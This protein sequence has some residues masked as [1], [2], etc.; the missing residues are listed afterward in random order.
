MWKYR[1]FQLLF[2]ILVGG[3]VAW[4]DHPSE[5]RL[6]LKELISLAET[7]NLEIKEANTKL[8]SLELSVWSRYGAFSPQLFV[9][10]GPVSTKFD[11]ETN[12]GSALFGRLRWNLYRGGYDLALLQQTKIQRNLEVQRLEAVKSRVRRQVSERYY[13]LLFILES[14]DLN[15]RALRM[16]AEQTK[17]ALARKASGFTSRAD[18]IEFELRESTLKSDLVLLEQQREQ[19]LRELSVLLGGDQQ[20][21]ALSVKGHLHR[22]R[23]KGAQDQLSEWIDL[24]NIDLLSGRAQVDTAQTTKSMVVSDFLPRVDLDARYGRLEQDGRVFSRED[25]YF[26]MLTFSVPIFSGLDTWNALRSRNELVSASQTNMDQVKLSL[27]ADLKNTLSQWAAISR[28]LDLEEVNLSRSEEYY[29]ITLGEYRR[30]V[31]NSPDVV[32]ASERLLDA[33][34]R[35]LGYRRDLILTKLKIFELASSDP[36]RVA[37]I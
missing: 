36:T 6:E 26:L 5:G 29:K 17:I 2:G 11:D 14:M 31:K 15:Q 16:N 9:E 24:N 35:N 7:Q 25:N 32:G 4:G 28:R 1:G 21:L 12:S 19:K 10:G 30:G 22:A 20:G 33:K 34:I 18:V 27:H 23:I 13:E 8:S 3:S 37:E